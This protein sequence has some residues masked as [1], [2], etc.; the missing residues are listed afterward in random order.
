MSDAPIPV[1][2]SSL[3][4]LEEYIPLLEQ[5]WASKQLTNGGTFH[6][7]LEARLGEYLGVPHV[8]LFSSCTAALFAGLKILGLKGEVITTPFTFIATAN[9]LMWCDLKPVFVDIDP[10]TANI[11]PAAIEKAI[12]P[13]TCAILAVHCYAQACDTKAIEEIAKKHNLKV[14]YDAAH[15]FGVED[16]NGSVLKAG[17]LSA[18]SFHAAKVFNT[19]EGGALISHDAETK[20]RIDSF[21]N[22]GFTSET[23]VE[24]CGFNGKMSE[25]SAA[26][27]IVQL[28]H[29]DRYIAAR[30]KVDETYR[31]WLKDIPGIELFSFANTKRTNHSY[32]PIRITKEYKISRDELYEQLKAKNIFTRRYFHPIITD[33]TPY[34]HMQAHTPVAKHL[35]T[36]I[37]CLPMYEGLTGDEQS[38]IIDILKD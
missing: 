8:S 21:K 2:R 30:K 27:G 11:D 22:F 16:A 1:T 33:F 32:F 34:K 12:T 20:K 5:L 14:I 23:T 28:G 26:L 17:D 3:P 24:G 37:L 13:Q 7:Q 15:A 4:P 25:L 6:Q 31:R 36:E 35:A 19:A 38:R 18:I 9:A 10:V 29:I